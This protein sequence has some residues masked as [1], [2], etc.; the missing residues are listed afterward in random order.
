ME[1]E[2]RHWASATG[3]LPDYISPCRPH[4]ECDLEYLRL[5]Y[6]SVNDCQL[7]LPTLVGRILDVRENDT[8][9]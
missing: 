8:V 1:E 4:E 9:C 2:D 6:Q 5:Q 3:S 7:L